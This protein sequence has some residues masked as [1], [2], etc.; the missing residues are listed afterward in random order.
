MAIKDKEVCHSAGEV[1]D[2]SS[3]KRREFLLSRFKLNTE[4]RLAMIERDLYELKQDLSDGRI[5]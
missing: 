1:E 3:S 2:Q 4:E 5:G